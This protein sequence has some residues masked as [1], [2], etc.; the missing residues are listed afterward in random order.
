MTTSGS[1]LPPLATVDRLGLGWY[2]STRER[3]ATA[4]L[5][6]SISARERFTGRGRDDY[7]AAAE[8][9]VRAAGRLI[10]VL[11]KAIENK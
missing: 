3:I 8:D 10:A 2:R 1:A 9:A 6:A 11:D 7:R 5:A 4:V